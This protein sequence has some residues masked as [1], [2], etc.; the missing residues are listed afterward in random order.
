MLVLRDISIKVR[1][2]FP[3]MYSVVEAGF[4][5]EHEWEMMKKYDD[6][7]SKYWIPINW[8]FALCVKL[9]Q[10]GKIAADVLLNGILTEVRT[11]HTN[12][13]TLCNYDWVPVPLAYP[14]VCHFY[15]LIS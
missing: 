6:E 12:L 4:L 13:R 8:I 15:F 1:K 3:N 9:R 10:N 14:Q 11:F 7:F 5:Q 2:R